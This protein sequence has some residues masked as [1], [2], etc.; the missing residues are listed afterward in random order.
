MKSSGRCRFGRWP[1][2]SVHLGAA[3]RRCGRDL[4][5]VL[6]RSE[7]VAVADDDEERDA[8]RQRLRRVGPVADRLDGADE[9]LGLLLDG[10]RACEAR[11]PRG[12]IPAGKNAG[13]TCSQIPSPPRSRAISIHSSRT[14]RRSGASASARE[15]LRTTPEQAL[16][17]EPRERA[18][19]VAAHRGADDDEL[20]RHLLQ[21][22]QRPLVD[23]RARARRASARAPRGRRA[24]R[25]A[26]PT[27]ARRTAARGG[28]RS[29]SRQR[30]DD[31]ELDRDR[32][33]ARA[34]RV[35]P[36]IEVRRQVDAEHVLRA[37]APTAGTRCRRRAG[38]RGRARRAARR[39]GSDHRGGTRSSRRRGRCR[40]GSTWSAASARAA[41]SAGSSAGSG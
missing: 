7:R 18:C 6:R 37:R 29:S 25:A 12:R 19:G 30:G 40:S 32:R 5:G 14:G 33:A 16:G 38:R 34:A 13:A 26:A 39:G 21:D 20:T 23:A 15:P 35:E 28:A 10:D 3:V 9:V 31:V 41:G 27:S 22:T 17:S 1:T 2:P 24:P 4:S 11:R 8:A 36:R